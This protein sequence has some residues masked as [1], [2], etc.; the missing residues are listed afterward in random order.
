MDD[1]NK[2]E[3]INEGE[4]HKKTPTT[5]L[6][7][8]NQVLSPCNFDMQRFDNTISFTILSFFLERKHLLGL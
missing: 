4:V 7:L 2:D 8:Q 5:T 6:S 1:L 3:Y